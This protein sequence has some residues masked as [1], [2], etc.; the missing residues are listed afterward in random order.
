MQLEE[1]AELTGLARGIAFQIAESLG[2]LERAKVLHEVRSLDQDGRAA[3]RRP[4]SASAPI[5][6]TCRRS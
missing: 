3:L 6:S 1:H 5:T 4:A 2:V